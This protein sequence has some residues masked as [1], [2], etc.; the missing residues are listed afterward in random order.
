MRVH[1]G[2]EMCSRRDQDEFGFPTNSQSQTPL[3]AES[4]HGALTCQCLRKNGVG[5]GTQF[6]LIHKFL[7][8][9]M[10][11]ADMNCRNFN[12]RRCEILLVPESPLKGSFEFS[13]SS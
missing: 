10:K 6:Q 1:L 4:T 9:Q 2:E 7:L 11:T 5:T 3:E 12:A 8:F 13:Q